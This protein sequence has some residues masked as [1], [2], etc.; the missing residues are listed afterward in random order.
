MKCVLASLL[1]A[2]AGDTGDRQPCPAAEL[3]DG[4]ID[5]ERH[6]YDTR[7]LFFGLLA[8]AGL[9]ALVL[10]TMMGLRSLIVTFRLMQLFGSS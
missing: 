6:Y 8:A 9:W 7:T 4:S 3:V 5:V 2:R 1:A 10:E